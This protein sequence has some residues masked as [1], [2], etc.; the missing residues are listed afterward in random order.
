MAWHHIIPY[1]LLRDVWNR[2]VDQHIATQLPEA[3]IAIRQYLI[4]CDPTLSNR[5]NLI[6]RIRAESTA[7]RRA[8]HHYLQPLADDEVLRLQTAAVWP[9]WN[10]VEGPDKDCRSDDPG[11]HQV[12]RFTHGLTAEQVT[13][14]REAELLFRPFQLF[15]AAG[16][17]P[18]PNS[19]GALAGSAARARPFLGGDSPIRYSSDIWIKD[20]ST[21]K[22]HKRRDREKDASSSLH[23]AASTSA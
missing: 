20:P 23:G 17:A 4:L 8:G 16:P 21:G 7:Q 3:R 22:W 9:A 1:H 10:T 6:D 12:D 2:L 15:V 14:T 11:E 5:D 19:L 18:G 13:R